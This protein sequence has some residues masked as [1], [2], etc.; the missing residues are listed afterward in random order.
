MFLFLLLQSTIQ[1]VAELHLLSFGQCV[2]V[3]GQAICMCVGAAVIQ[4]AEPLSSTLP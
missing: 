2:H 3:G 1:R 4:E